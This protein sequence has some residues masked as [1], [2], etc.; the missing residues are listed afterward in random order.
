MDWTKVVKY[1]AGRR[2]EKEEDN[3]GCVTEDG[4][5]RR[6]WGPLKGAA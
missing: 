1:G 3:K 2:E 6:Q 5:R 4:V